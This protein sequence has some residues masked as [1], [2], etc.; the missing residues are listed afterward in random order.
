MIN[1][2]RGCLH[3]NAG[4]GLARILSLGMDCIALNSSFM[5]LS[6][7]T[8]ANYQ[9]R[10]RF[11]ERQQYPFW[12]VSLLFSKETEA[13]LSPLCSSKCWKKKIFLCNF[14]P[15]VLVPSQPTQGCY[16]SGKQLLLMFHMDDCGLRGPTQK[17]E[18]S[19]VVFPSSF[20]HFFFSAFGD[21]RCEAEPTEPW[22]VT[23][24]GCNRPAVRYNSHT[25]AF[26]RVSIC[27]PL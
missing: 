27:A 24:Q 16:L 3:W 15:L 2:H 4:R 6:F 23:G 5:F 12:V 21:F 25:H 17:Y 20:M 1:I 26:I 7:S 14:I 11:D 22:T 9:I 13:L 19:S 18:P 8:S 10:S